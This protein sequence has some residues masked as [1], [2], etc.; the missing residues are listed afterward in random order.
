MTSA[1]LSTSGSKIAGIKSPYPSTDYNPADMDGS[2]NRNRTSNGN[3]TGG[4]D[5]Y[6]TANNPA[7]P[8]PRPMPA[9]SQGGYTT[10]STY[11]SGNTDENTPNPKY[12]S[13]ASSHPQCFD[14]FGAKFGERS[15]SGRSGKGRTKRGLP[16]G[17]APA[18]EGGMQAVLSSNAFASGVSQNCGN[19]ITGRPSS[20]VTA[21]PGG[22]STFSLG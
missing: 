17:Y 14:G 1:R 4:L 18:S 12:V 16:P 6:D 2:N 19:F 9:T 5:N 13:R 11:G 10:S 3:T 15:G 20:R 7:N 21:P 8:R 22:H